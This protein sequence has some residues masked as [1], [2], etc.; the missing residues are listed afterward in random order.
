LR[1]APFTSFDTLREYLRATFNLP[2]CL[3][4]H[5]PRHD[6]GKFL[7]VPRREAICRN[8][9]PISRHAAASHRWSNGVNS[10]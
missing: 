2:F 8:I 3:T 6:D 4:P 5:N 10:A 1:I 7:V 9:V